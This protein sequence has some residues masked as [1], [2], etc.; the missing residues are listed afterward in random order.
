MSPATVQLRKQIIA[1]QKKYNLSLRKLGTETDV[2]Y[3]TLFKFISKGIT[4]SDKTC[5]KLEKFLLSLPV[6]N[7]KLSIGGKEFE[8]TLKEVA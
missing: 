7:Q 5:M 8:I 6:L 1:A 2:S 4:I 3:I